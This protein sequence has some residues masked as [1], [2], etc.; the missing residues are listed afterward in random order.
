MEKEGILI[1]NRATGS[2]IQNTYKTLKI[3]STKS[4]NTVETYSKIYAGSLQK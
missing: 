3:Y 1:L 4:G 2:L